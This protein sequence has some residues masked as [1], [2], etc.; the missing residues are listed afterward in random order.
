MTAI[1]ESIETRITDGANVVAL[2]REHAAGISARVEEWSEGKLG[3]SST[4][5]VMVTQAAL[6][7]EANVALVQAAESFEALR[8]AS[9]E[10]DLALRSAAADEIERKLWDARGRI[11]EAYGAEMLKLYDLDEPPPAGVR[12][13][14]TYAHNAVT[15][16]RTH[17]QSLPSAFQDDL[18]TTLFVTELE[19]PMAALDDYLATLESA[20]S[21]LK[22]ALDHFDVAH[23]HWMRTWR[24][25]STALEGVFMMGGRGDLAAM[26]RPRL[27]SAPGG[28]PAELES[29]DA[30][31]IEFTSEL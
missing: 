14:A 4:E 1:M 18:D 27:P 22:S 12:A 16:L 29:L 9:R 23:E 30:S 8:S 20:S 10:A 25:V 13:L 26:V 6:L 24:G 5:E 3:A 15:L 17:P 7:E 2:A 11:I 19:A 21:D 28:L 31:E